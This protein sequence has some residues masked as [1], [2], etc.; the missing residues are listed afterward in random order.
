MTADK[1]KQGWKTLN[2]QLSM[3]L[4][5]QPI[6]TWDTERIFGDS[7]TVEDLRTLKEALQTFERLKEKSIEKC[8]GNLYPYLHG[9][10]IERSES[11]RERLEA[12]LKPIE[13][14]INDKTETPV[15]EYDS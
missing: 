11:I 2:W 12:T 8:T 4:N 13:D 14:D 9:C 15:E 7:L 6:H 10:D 5:K 1:N 3:E